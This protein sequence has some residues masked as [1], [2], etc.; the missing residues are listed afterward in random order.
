[1]PRSKRTKNVQPFTYHPKVEH[2]SVCAYLPTFVMVVLTA[3]E[4]YYFVPELLV[5][6]HRVSSLYQ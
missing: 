6:A 4:L 3:A 5:C 2:T 1:M